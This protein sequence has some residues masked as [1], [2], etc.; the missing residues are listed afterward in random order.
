MTTTLATVAW[1]HDTFSKEGIAYWIFGGFAVDLHVGEETRVHDDVDVAVSGSD[2]ERAAACLVAA[3]FSRDPN[4]AAGY[5]TFE[6]DDARIDLAPTWPS[7]AFGDDV[8]ELGGVRARVV[9]RESLIADKSERRDDP[10]TRA[11]DA[12]DLRRLVPSE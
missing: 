2:F 4:E 11:K 9:T 6:R 1:L 10:T 12:A 8:R 7:D 3:G 5:S